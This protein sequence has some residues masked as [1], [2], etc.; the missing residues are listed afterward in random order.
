MPFDARENAFALRLVVSLLC[1]CFRVAHAA[2]FA[3]SNFRFV[4]A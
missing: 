1:L 2:S 4:V 3:A